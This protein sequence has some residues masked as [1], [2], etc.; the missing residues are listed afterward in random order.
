MKAYLIT[1]G[2]L[3]G[4]ITVAHLW[5]IV[6]EWPQL[7]T[8]SWYLLLTVAAASLSLWAWRLVRLPVRRAD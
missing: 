7:A 1:T 5:R 2:G 3:F 4:L 8:D 6:D